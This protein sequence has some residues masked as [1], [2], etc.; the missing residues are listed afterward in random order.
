MGTLKFYDEGKSY[1][2]IIMDMDGTDIFVHCDDLTKAGVNKEF[3][4][5]SK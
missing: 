4:R 1:G 5:T 3:L 2:F